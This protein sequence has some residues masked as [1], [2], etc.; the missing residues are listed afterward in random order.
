MYKSFWIKLSILSLYVL[1]SPSFSLPLFDGKS[2]LYD[3]GSNGALKYGTRNAYSGMYYLRVNGANYVGNIEQLSPDGREV[4]HET[5][6]ELGSGLEVKR[7]FYVSKTENF[8]RFSEILRNPTDAPITVDVEIYGQLGGEKHTAILDQ[9]HFLITDDVING[10]SGVMPVLLHYHSQV[11]NPVTAKH[12]LSDNQLNWVYSDVTIPAQSQVRLIYFVAQTTDVNIAQQ[13]ATQIY[14]N[15]TVLYEGMVALEQSLTFEAKQPTPRDGEEGDFSKVPFLHL[16]ELRTGALT[17]EDSWSL[18]RVA[19]PADAYALKLAAGETVTIRMSAGFNAYLYLFQ[20][21][22]G[23]KVVMANDDRDANT[24]HAEMV[25]TA[26]EEGTYYIEAT[27]H[28]RSERGSYA[29]EILAGSANRPPTAYPFDFKAESFT[30][31]ATVTLTDFNTD[32]DGDIVERC[33]HF[34]DASPKTCDG[35]NTVTHTYQKAGQYNVSL[36]LR[37]NEGAYAYHNEQISITSPFEGIVLRL[38]NTVSGELGP[39]DDYS[40]TRYHAFADRYRITSVI[41][42]QE[43]VVDMISDEFDSYL[44]LYNRFNQLLHQDNNG[45]GSTHARLRYT[46]LDPEDLWIEATSFGDNT[47]GKYQLTLEHQDNSSVVDIP[48]DVSPTLNPLQYLFIARLPSR[49]KATA[50]RWQ[51]GDDTKEVSTDQPIISHT[52]SV[53]GEVTVTLTALNAERQQLTGTKKVRVRDQATT[54]TIRFRAIPLFGEAPLRVFFTNESSP[55]SPEEPLKYLW[56]FG[57][58]KI[59]TDTNPSYTFTQAGNYYVTLQGFSSQQRGSYTLPITVIDRGSTSLPVTGIVRE[60]PQV[61]MAGFDPILVDLLETQVKIFSIVRP[62]KTPIQT[63]R[64]ITKSD[65]FELIMQHVATYA[66]GDQRYETVLT[67][68]QG[69]LPVGKFGNFFGEQQGQF[70]I[71]ATD[72]AGQFHAFPNL[73]IGNNPPLDN[74]SIPK[75]LNIEPLRREYIH[76]RQPQVLAA[77]FDPI[78]V[79][80]NDK[81]PALTKAGD[82]EFMIKA[83]VREGLFPIQSVTVKHNQGNLNFPMRLQETLPNGDKLYVVNYAYPS[84]SFEKSTLGN[85]FGTEPTQFTVVVEDLGKQTHRFPELEIGHFPER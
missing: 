11:N 29:L 57:D 45:G 81:V 1:S 53:A 19:T 33:W 28:N 61:L 72:Q 75:S 39:S 16:G 79:H 5:F 18:K 15:P 42:N 37:D 43:L 56:Q 58:G 65:D 76:R 14:T 78:L 80:K 20:G 52:Y 66:N 59:E 23:E 46:P 12:S 26:T 82:T 8:A 85:L 6:T 7:Y 64:L 32:A 2:F 68:A 54:P 48:I 22:N 63:V 25:F 38:S 44:Y 30:A 49:F 35:N 27:A 69:S 50:L 71:Q 40:Q 10:I 21:V 47:L 84:N 73:E 31:P 60:L 51:F 9:D 24:T 83:I 74:P 62:G 4:H 36:T 13:V 17:E 77:G 70:R 55:S 34:D 3:I 67:F 41:A